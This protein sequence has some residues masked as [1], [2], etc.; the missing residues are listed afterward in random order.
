MSN[1]TSY[2]DQHEYDIRC[3]WG[4]EGIRALAPISDVIVIVDV[5]SFCTCVDIAA[6]NGASVYL[7]RLRDYSAQTYAD[8]LGAVLAS[9]QRSTDVYSLSPTSLVDIPAGARLVL[10][11]PN[12]AT[13][14]LTTGDV[15]TFAGCLRNARAVAEAARKVG[16]RISVIPAGERWPGDTLRPA[17]EDII[18]AGAIISHLMHELGGY[19]SPEAEAA[20]AVYAHF[21]DQLYACIETCGSGRELVNRG[22]ADDIGLAADLNASECAPRLV[23]GAYVCWTP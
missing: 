16:R 21:W 9:F 7:Y 8:S 3:E 22:F 23:D 12:G 17:I 1:T 5:L 18:G 13:L 10:P 19:P 20:E 6:S 2:F 11:S 15:P 4:I 14:T